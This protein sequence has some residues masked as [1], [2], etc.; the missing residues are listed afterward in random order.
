MIVTEELPKYQ[1]QVKLGKID[2]YD[3][4]EY[5]TVREIFPSGQNRTIGQAQFTCFLLRNAF[6][7]RIK[8]IED[9]E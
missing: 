9:Q 4:N 3:E 7:K 1:H 6:G 5:H 2:K 8:T